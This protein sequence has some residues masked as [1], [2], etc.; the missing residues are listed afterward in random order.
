MENAQKVFEKMPDTDVISQNIM[1]TQLKK[2]ATKFMMAC[3]D[4]L[5]RGDDDSCYCVWTNS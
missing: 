4:S 5:K 3:G 1:I 2:Y